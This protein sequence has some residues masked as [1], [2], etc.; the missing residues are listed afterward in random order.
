MLEG[1][2]L[3][4]IR[5]PNTKIRYKRNIKKAEGGWGR[6]PKEKEKGVCD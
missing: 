3:Y 1:I 4:G 6:K 5:E 2:R